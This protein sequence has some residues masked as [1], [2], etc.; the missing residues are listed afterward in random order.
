MEFVAE[1]DIMPHTE[2]LDPQGNAV[3]Q[4]MK[5]LDIHGVLNV[6]IG[7]HVTMA[8]EAGSAEE[9]REKVEVACQKLLANQIMESYQ[10]I[11]N[12]K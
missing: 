4:N 6:R 2:L 9:A 3:L 5:Y 8:V 12:P 11:L 1:I 7:R 10:Y